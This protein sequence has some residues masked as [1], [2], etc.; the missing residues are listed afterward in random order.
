[1]T[2]ELGE[3]HYQPHGWRDEDATQID[4]CADMRVP[5]IKEQTEILR[6]LGSVNYEIIKGASVYVEVDGVVYKTLFG[7]YWR[8]VY[9]GVEHYLLRCK[10]VS[11][12]IWNEDDPSYST[13]DLPI[14]YL[15]QCWT[16]GGHGLSFM[17]S[18]D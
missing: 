3:F 13:V 7:G 2:W 14:A 16:A 18:K 4:D 17:L 1:M 9:T 5:N 10:Q 8:S 15:N 6:L 12:S 11:G